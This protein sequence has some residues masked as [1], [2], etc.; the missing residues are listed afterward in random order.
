[1][2]PMK[3]SEVVMLL[4]F[5]LVA[6][7]WM[8]TK[9]HG[10]NYAAVAMLGIC[11][12]LVS[13]VLSWGDLIDERG[14]WGVFI[15]YGGLVRMAEAL[16]QTG[17]YEEVCRFR[18]FFHSRME[19]VVSPGGSFVDL[20]LCALRICEYHRARDCD[21]YTVPRCDS[22]GGYSAIP[23]RTVACILFES[24]RVADA[25]WHNSRADLFWC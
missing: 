12:L 3:W 19:M 15:W 5:A 7:L 18:R 1:M 6:I 10:I 9:F 4:V 8:T 17:Y 21:V 25:L 24:R 14:A 2:G 13:G 11:V 16:G 23:R 20:F 22:C